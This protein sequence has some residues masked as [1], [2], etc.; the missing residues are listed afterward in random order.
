LD[1]GLKIVGKCVE[2][3]ENEKYIS[4]EIELASDKVRG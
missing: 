2:P 4:F 1:V 3:Y